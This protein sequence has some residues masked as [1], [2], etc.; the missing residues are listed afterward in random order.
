MRDSPQRLPN[1]IEIAVL[2]KLYRH[3]YIGGRHTA[4]ADIHKGFPSDKRGEIDW[5]VK[6]LTRE[7]F[8]I[9]K[10]TGYGIHYSLNPRIVSQLKQILNEEFGTVF[11][12]N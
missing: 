2:E 7:G 8:L 11:D 9:P 12:D 3:G 4:L 5:A 10:I 6:K 1:G